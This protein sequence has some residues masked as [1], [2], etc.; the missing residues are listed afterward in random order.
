MEV[1][2]WHETF[3]TEEFSQKRDINK[4]HLCGRKDKE[5]H[6]M[7]EDSDHLNVER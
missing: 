1:Y 6:K 3:K 4:W 7:W 5:K 2:G